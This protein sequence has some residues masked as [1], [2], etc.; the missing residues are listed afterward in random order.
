MVHEGAEFRGPGSPRGLFLGE[1][2]FD[3]RPGGLNRYFTDLYD[4]LGA[5]SVSR[6][7]VVVDDLRG[8]LAKRL[9][10]YRGAAARE[11]ARADVV[12]AHFALYAFLAV[13]TTS[14][15]RRPLVVHFQ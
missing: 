10:T 12:D 7:A 8:S 15:R 1:A 11:R 14:L 6:R 9:L 4:A 5:A 2:W 3:P 13:F